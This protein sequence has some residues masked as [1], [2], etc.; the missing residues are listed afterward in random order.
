MDCTRCG[1]ENPDRAK[2]CLDCGAQ[3]AAAAPAVE[4][5]KTVTVVF[6]DVTGSTALGES[7][8]PE[9]VRS[10][11]ARYFERMSGII[12]A[13]GGAVEK[14]IGDAVMAVFGVPVL[15][16]DDALRA[17]RAAL[18]MRDALPEIG[19]QA[20]IGIN[21]G[22][23]VTGT[24]ERL[25]TGDAV[26][27]AARL[28]QAALPD[29]VLLGAQTVKLVR[30]A[31]EVEA[32]EPLRLKGKEQPVDAFRLLALTGREAGARRL[33]GTFV[34]RERERRML[35]EAFDLAVSDQACHLFTMLGVAGVGK[36][37]LAAEFLGEVDATVVRGRCLSYGDGITYW[38]VVEVVKHLRP[39]ELEL[40]PTVARPLR[41]L[42]GSDER[43]TA[44]EIAF[45]VRK[46]LEEAA[47]E[48]PLVVVWDDLHWAEPTFLDL[49]E[50]VADWSR[51][52]PILLLCMARPELLDSR[53]GWAGGKLHATTVLV[54]PLGRVACEALL[55]DLGADLEPE[56]R[57]KI[58]A[59]ADGNPLFVEEMVAMVRDSPTADV[60]VPPTISA[61][62][63]ARL[64]QLAAPERAALACGSVEGSVFHRTAVAALEGDPA[65]LMGLVRK[66]LVRPDKGTLPGD[67]AFRFRH[68]L[69]RDAAYE[70]LPKSTRAKLH[71]RFADWVEKRSPELVELDEIVGYHLE[72]ATRYRLELGALTARELEVAAR[73]AER[74][75]AAGER[76]LSHNDVR[77]SASLLR[78]GLALL[79]PGTRAVDQEWRLVQALMQSG[80][81]A[82]ARDQA[83][84]LAARGAAAD[85]R[86][87]ALYGRLA[88]SFVV[89][90]MEPEDASMGSL[91]ELAADAQGQFEA[92]QDELGLGLCWLA[93]AH[94]DHN[95]CRWQA[96]QD[97]LERAYLHGGRAG[98]H[99]LQEHSLLWMAA[100]A[101]HG[102][103]PTDEGLRWFADH[104]DELGDAPLVDS[105]RS[106]V[107]AMVG[108]FDAAR[109]TSRNARRRLEELGL[110]LW[111][112]ATGMHTYAI[113]TYAGDHAA[114]AREGIAGC[115]ALQ[116][117]G[118]RGWLSTLAGETAHTLLE[119][120]RDEEAEHWLAVAAD[121]G[122]ADDVMTQALIKEVEARLLSRRGQHDA[123]KISAHDALALIDRT[124]ML[125]T[126]ADSK[127]NLAEI[128]RAAGPD[129]DAERLQA[130]EEA[131][132]LY[133]Q[134]RHLVGM[135][136]AAA[137]LESAR[138]PT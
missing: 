65:Q 87:A 106:T 19:V 63:S 78:R 119:L 21:T 17:V 75:L 47:S 35:R 92:T 3:L 70:A 89:F 133:E 102:P 42:L 33:E 64:D 88:S 39:E 128:L 120:G 121:A 99:Y 54:E 84:D 29:E 103:M 129:E 46:L 51:A 85:D 86:R 83:D 112:A 68:I 125:D 16:E 81:L 37:R 109:E 117:I 110:G 24:A 36:S 43:A 6:C 44:E 28:E 69:I 32:V 11:L 62:L 27:V 7:T 96:R 82:Q 108:N 115:E 40:E 107:E 8:D 56:L 57:T 58:L 31:V 124:D 59:S 9:A 111:L 74:L 2:F 97:A 34:G 60:Q 77:A 50:H 132:A 45:A 66:E 134:K 93:L 12:E 38:P 52:A 72:Q 26:N 14:F 79:P 23:V 116:A 130:I 76:A 126:I 67:D 18:E 105:M 20:R 136:R 61:L 138:L 100:G 135:A 73:A 13:H 48:R 25:A 10:L 80:E 41:V 71:E 101:V 104:A 4:V 1:A 123:A 30:D 22:E 118:E 122:S 55:D 127:L 131:A 15:H 90:L 5:R 113:E 49:I 114:A 91:A 98:D 95:A 53:T 137:L 94:V